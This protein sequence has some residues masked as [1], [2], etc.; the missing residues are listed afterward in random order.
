MVRQLFVMALLLSVSIAFAQ[1]T[2]KKKEEEKPPTQK[3]MEKMTKVAQKV[4]FTEQAHSKE[5]NKYM[6]KP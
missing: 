1:P 6:M 5:Q 2:G 4:P 3:E